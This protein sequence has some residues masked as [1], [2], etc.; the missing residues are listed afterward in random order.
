VSS[1]A[2][3][4]SGGAW[5]RLAALAGAAATGLA[6]VSGSLGIEHSAVSAF[7]V[8][9]LAAVAVAAWWAHRRLVPASHLAL[10]LFG[11]AAAV[12]QPGFHAALAAAA[13]AAAAVSAAQAF[14]GAPLPAGAWRDYVTLTKPR[15]MSL[16]L[17]TG[18]AVSTFTVEARSVNERAERTRPNSSARAGAIR[19][20]A[21]GRF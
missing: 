5:L 20:A 2:A 17:V 9:P 21:T 19:P 14:R 10:V 18:A 15:I 11:L 12:T 8:P 16:L 3:P 7:A 1:N 4:T 13:L 6:V